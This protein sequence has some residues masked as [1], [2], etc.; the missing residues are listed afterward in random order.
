M[1]AVTAKGQTPASNSV[2]DICHA[3]SNIELYQGLS[4]D[5]LTNPSLILNVS[6]VSYLYIDNL[7]MNNTPC[8]IAGYTY[9]VAFYIYNFDY[10][11]YSNIS[12]IQSYSGSNNLNNIII[13]ISNYNYI[14]L[15]SGVLVATNSIGSVIIKNLHFS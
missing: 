15:I 6:G 14:R 8:T 4:I 3:I 2:D 13:N 7:T 11:S 1:Q 5:T 10:Y 12:T 9:S